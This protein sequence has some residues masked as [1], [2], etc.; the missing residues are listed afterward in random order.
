[1]SRTKE[2]PQVE[3][4]DSVR[5]KAYRTTRRTDNRSKDERRTSFGVRLVIGS[6]QKVWRATS[7]ANRNAEMSHLDHGVVERRGAQALL[8]GG[9]RSCKLRA[10]ESPGE[11]E[12]ECM[13]TSSLSQLTRRTQPKFAAKRQAWRSLWKQHTAAAQY[14]TY[15]PG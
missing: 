1:M 10:Q 9:G 15:R 6:T 3:L 2:R 12:C 5:M 14:R 7:G 13:N 4:I 11:T 8:T